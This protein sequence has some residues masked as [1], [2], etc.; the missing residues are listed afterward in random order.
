MDVT[1]F[2]VLNYFNYP[3]MFELFMNPKVKFITRT[4]ITI[5]LDSWQG[6][7]RKLHL[8]IIIVITLSLLLQLIKQMCQVQSQFMF[9]INNQRNRLYFVTSFSLV[10][11]FLYF[12]FIGLTILMQSPNHLAALYFVV[13]FSKASNLNMA[14]YLVICLL[15]LLHDHLLVPTLLILDIKANLSFSDVGVI[16][17]N[18]FTTKKL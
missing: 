11:H 18:L 4:F 9:P 7:S 3:T 2:V 12:Q 5:Q 6:K 15:S 14:N 16:L 1:L 17:N 13:C 8:L 10:L